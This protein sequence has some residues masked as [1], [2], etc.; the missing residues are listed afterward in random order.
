MSPQYRTPEDIVQERWDDYLKADRVTIVDSTGSTPGASGGA[1]FTYT[2][3][4]RDNLTN[5]YKTLESKTW[6]KTLSWDA[7]DRLIA[8]TPWVEV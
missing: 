1:Y 3:D 8:I 5:I 7:K 6:V 4:A 2:W